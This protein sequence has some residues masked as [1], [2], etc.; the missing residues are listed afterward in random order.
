[1]N[2]LEKHLPRDERAN[3]KFYLK[4]AN[5]NVEVVILQKYLHQLSLVETGNISNFRYIR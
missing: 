5:G 3:I 1:M 4:S 2:F